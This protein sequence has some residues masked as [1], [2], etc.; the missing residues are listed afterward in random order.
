MEILI[1]LSVILLAV[2]STINSVLSIKSTRRFTELH[3][4]IRHLERSAKTTFRDQG[5]V[6][7]PGLHRVVNHT[8]DPEYFLGPDSH[9]GKETPQ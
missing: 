3:D 8:G 4:R 6:I 2:A 1:P 5:A 7:R 9:L